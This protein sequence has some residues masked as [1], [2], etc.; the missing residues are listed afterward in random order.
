MPENVK[1]ESGL[2]V[3][4]TPIGNMA[5]ITL[6]A[7]DIL[8][9]ADVILSEDTRV[10]GKLLSRHGIK[11]K[12]L[13][14][15]EHN[16]ARVRPGILARLEAGQ[17][18]ALVSD[19]GTPL[20]SDP[21]FKL[22][23][24]ARGIGVMVT[25]L[26]GPS[27]VINALAMAGLPCSRF[28]FYGFLPARRGQRLKLLEEVAGAGA[29]L[30]FFESTKRLRAS[31]ADMKEVFGPERRVAVA[32]EMTKRFE[33]VLVK[34][35]DQ[36]TAELEARDSIKGEVTVL[37]EPAAQKPGRENEV[38]QALIQA[39]KHLSVREAASAV[40]YLT[41]VKRRQVYARALELKDEAP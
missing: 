15:H 28:C 12:L 17:I 27:A 29:T 9:K 8:G 5:D 13:S 14:Y 26:P 7:L 38:D 16:A 37:V 23:E 30:I 4:A 34:P 24:E 20:I 10:T 3:T 33:E 36:L 31:L 25:S 22:V 6:R 40:A 21:G 11:S 39:L 18:V 41:G 35:L 2:Y 1:P 32:R 19:A